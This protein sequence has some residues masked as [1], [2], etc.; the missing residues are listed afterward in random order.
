MLKGVLMQEILHQLIVDSL[1]TG[2]PS[3]TRRDAR[4]PNIANKAHAV[5]GMRRSGKT[6]FL[7]QCLADRMEAGTP[8]EAL[9]YLNFEDERLAGLKAENLQWIVEDY[10]R[11]LPQWRDHRTV[12]FFF[13]EIQLI[14]GWERFVRRIMDTERIGVF[15][16]GSSARLLS[17]EIATSMRGRTL[18]T[19]I[20]PFSFREVLRHDGMEP[21][22]DWERLPK[23]VRSGI[24][25][26]LRHYLVEGGFPEALGA[27]PS[28]RRL[29]L[30]SYIDVAI[31]RDVIERH[32]VSNPVA[33]RWIQR[34]LL[35][36]PAGSFSIQKHYET[37]RSQGLPVSKDTLHAYLSYLEDAFLLR[38]ISIHARSERKRM[39]NPRKVYPID[40]GLITIYQRSISADTGHALETV[41]MLELERRGYEIG[42]LRTSEGYEVDF[43]AQS[44]TGRQLLI[45]VTMT[46][47]AT[48]TY[49]R[50]VRALLAASSEYPDAEPILITL[51][52][53]PPNP[54]LPDPLRWQ[55]AAEWLLDSAC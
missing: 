25:A 31:L 3:F 21:S 20:H 27:T 17:R 51:D 8:R 44:T 30:R 24:D 10:F 7:W 5:I 22:Q 14:E 29:L 42:Y 40:P 16:S 49:A 53:I 1:H 28:D 26:R 46:V 2:I 38:H 54:E 18:E 13:D 23:A 36:N 50:E 12:T 55:S 32:R 33:L 35:S 15:L 6:T 52:T 37:L 19:V 39:V 34:Q 43:F 4:L 45:Q 9:L 41:V 11:I 47:A 48:D